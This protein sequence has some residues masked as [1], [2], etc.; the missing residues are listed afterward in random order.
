MLLTQNKIRLL[1]RESLRR[2]LLGSE[3]ELD[4]LKAEFDRKVEELG[5]SKSA[6]EFNRRNAEIQE[7]EKRINGL[8]RTMFKEPE[9]P[10][11]FDFMQSDP[12][13]SPVPYQS[14]EMSAYEEDSLDR[15]AM[16]DV[17]GGEGNRFSG[18]PI[19]QRDINRR[20]FVQNLGVGIGASALLGKQILDSDSLFANA[21]PY[22]ITSTEFARFD[23]AAVKKYIDAFVDH[24]FEH[25]FAGSLESVHSGAIEN[26]SDEITDR[27]IHQLLETESA[28]ETREYDKLYDTLIGEVESSV[29]RYRGMP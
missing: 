28:G 16:I 15:P 20:E 21:D 9:E 19:T 13:D 24:E 22:S 1:I 12:I 2:I 6:E 4:R 11:E 3:D 14:G 26:I 10:G 29:M 7:L 23:D 5:Q 17:S 25:S 27:M 18:G 8:T